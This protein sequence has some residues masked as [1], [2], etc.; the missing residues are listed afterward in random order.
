[1]RSASAGS[2]GAGGAATGHP[3][4]AA[5]LPDCRYAFAALQWGAMAPSSLALIGLLDFLFCVVHLGA[6]CPTPCCCYGCISAFAQ[7]TAQLLQAQ[8]ILGQP[9]HK[10]TPCPHMLTATLTPS[11]CLCR[12][13]QSSSD[14]PGGQH[15]AAAAAAAG[16]WLTL[17]QTTV[18]SAQQTLNKVQ[19]KQHAPM[20]TPSLCLCRAAE[21]GSG[22]LGGQH[23]AAARAVGGQGHSGSGLL[24]WLRGGGKASGQLQLPPHRAA[25]ERQLHHPHRGEDFRV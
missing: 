2:A 8:Q 14:G 21:P 20:S 13:A 15:P 10:Q 3:G 1:M 22:G 16:C 7:P 25:R 19:Q 17:N 12:A 18:S 11:L 6:C 4:P 5:A 24:G 9:Q 23:P